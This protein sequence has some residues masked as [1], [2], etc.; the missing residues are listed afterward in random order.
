MEIWPERGIHPI[1]LAL[2]W[3]AVDLAVYILVSRRYQFT[4]K[5]I[6]LRFIVSF[7]AYVL[8]TAVVYSIVTPYGITA[9][10]ASIALAG[11]YTLSILESWTLFG[12]S[13]SLALLSHV[14]AQRPTPESVVARFTAE[15]ATRQ[16]DR[17]H[18]LRS[19]QLI[20]VEDSRAHLTARGMVVA[21]GLR[22]LSWIINV[23]SSG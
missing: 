2:V 5:T 22:L 17:L 20:R 21:R 13:L 14:G 9:I 12:S 1:L 8:T 6:F 18:S 16:H 10:L 3:C 19:L 15:G 7:L 23:R 11:M 4:E